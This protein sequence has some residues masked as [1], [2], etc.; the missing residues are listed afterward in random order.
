ML[1]ANNQPA[2]IGVWIH[3]GRSWDAMPHIGP[4]IVQDYSTSWWIWWKSMQPSW[5]AN[6][7]SRDLRGTAGDYNWDN[8]RKETQNG[9]FVVILSLGLWL[10]GLKNNG[11]NGQWPCGDAMRDVEWVLGQMLT[12]GEAAA[13]GK[14]AL[15]SGS[16]GAPPSQRSRNN[17]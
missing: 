4:G 12:S 17:K 10:R 8:L 15:S 7:L 5:R 14:R 6:N 11:E 9:F 16:A 3:D 2:P 13:L 1:S